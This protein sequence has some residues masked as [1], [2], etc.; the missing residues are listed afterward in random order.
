[1]KNATIRL[2]FLLA[3]LSAAGI[4]ATQVFWVKR[5][6]DLEEKEVNLKINVALR[7]VAFNIHKE[8]IIQP[9]SYNVVDMVNQEYFIVRLD[10]HPSSELLKHLLLESF[11]RNHLITDFQFAVYD[12]MKNT[13]TDTH[14]VH[15]SGSN[16]AFSPIDSFPKI[17]QANYYFGV[18]FPHRHKFIA[19]QLSVWVYSSIVLLCI[20]IFLAYVVFIILKQKRLSE[21]QKDFVNNM[22]H[23]FKTPLTS[24]QL[25]AEVLSKPDIVNKPQRLLNYAAIIELEA[26]QLTLQV[27]R[28]LQMANA[29]KGVLQLHKTPVCLQDLIK[30]V[31][32]IFES[33]IE[34]K[35]G[36]LRL[37]FPE[38][39]ITFS[40]DELHL[41]NAI[42]NLVDN[43]IKYSN[44]PVRIE[45]QLTS[46]LGEIEIA[47]VDNGIGID[48]SHQKM[49]FE[50]FYR[51][52]T[53][54]LHDVKGFGLGLNYVQLIARG[55]NG[56][57]YCSSQAGK[58][59]KFYINLKI[60]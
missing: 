10:H 43:A 49:L 52:P 17:E 25:A 21:V 57:A 18:Y 45:I 7:N 41:K 13:F 24:I 40:A 20:L 35:N 30:E 27:E 23:E 55:H 32:L 42:S 1:M 53:G 16:D 56:E 47:V 34:K 50:K 2:I 51:V 9:R 4:I 46:L 28:V 12:C 38:K 8:N 6:Y 44:E 22:T 14:Y 60:K 15:M 3:I 19:D 31:A 39:P 54:N 58:G 11:E 29:T 33:Q 26:A 37:N 5:A 59:S 36:I 48:K